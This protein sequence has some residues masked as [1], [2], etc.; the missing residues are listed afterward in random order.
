M[1]SE[2]SW[3]QNVKPLIPKPLLEL[4]TEYRFR[5]INRQVDA[6]YSGDDA[7]QVFS[8]IYKN[9]IWGQKPGSDFFLEGGV[10]TQHWSN[11]I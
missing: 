7:A 8:N 3:K 4:L 9:G 10:T 1:K 5:K 6:A 2:S 11:L